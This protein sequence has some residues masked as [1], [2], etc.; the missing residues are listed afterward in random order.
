MPTYCVIDRVEISED[1]E[2]RRAV[3]CSDE[4]KKKL[5]A[6]RR[7]IHEGKMCVFCKKPSTPE[8]RVLYAR[9]RRETFPQ[10]KKGR[11]SKSAN[12]TSIAT[13]TEP[14]GE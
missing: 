2:R 7:H 6:Q 3:T 12:A 5:N 4:C 8:E 11:P 9:W 10:A 1:R 13:E 14:A